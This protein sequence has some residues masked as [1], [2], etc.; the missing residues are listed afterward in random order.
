MLAIAVL[1]LGPVAWIGAIAAIAWA[2]G[3]SPYRATRP[4]ADRGT[5]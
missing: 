2:R 1:L 5:A 4:H 3:A